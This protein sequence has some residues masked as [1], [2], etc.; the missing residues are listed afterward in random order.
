MLQWKR[1]RFPVDFHV[2]LRNV[3]VNARRFRLRRRAKCL[4]LIL[5]QLKKCPSPGLRLNGRG[6]SYLV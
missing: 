5:I 6:T 1:F 4:Q 2:E 3:S